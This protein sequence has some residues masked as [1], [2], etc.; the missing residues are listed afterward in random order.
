VFFREHYEV[1]CFVFVLFNC[2]CAQLEGG[3]LYQL[4]AQN[5]QLS[6]LAIFTAEE[7][8]AVGVFAAFYDF[9]QVTVCIYCFETVVQ[10][11]RVAFSELVGLF[12]T[13]AMKNPKFFAG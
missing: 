10:E 9:C 1:I 6:L 13:T 4:E 3:A 7:E 11:H 8:V 5:V 2:A 12:E